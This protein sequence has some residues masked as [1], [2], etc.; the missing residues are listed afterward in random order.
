MSHSGDDNN[1]FKPQNNHY[2]L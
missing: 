1:K 2:Y